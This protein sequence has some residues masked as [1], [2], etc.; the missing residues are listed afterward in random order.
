MSLWLAH[1]QAPCAH[2]I[3][4][5]A[6]LQ[7]VGLCGE[8]YSALPTLPGWPTCPTCARRDAGMRL[9]GRQFSA[10]LRCRGVGWLGEKVKAPCE[11]CGMARVVV[12]LPREEV[13]ARGLSSYEVRNNR[14]GEAREGVFWVPARAED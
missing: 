2:L 10:C 1:V 4:S 6:G 13:L 11:A 14:P 9:G 5:E 8:L 3:S 12:R 7:H